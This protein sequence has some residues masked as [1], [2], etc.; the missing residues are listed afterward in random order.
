MSIKIEGKK[1]VVCSSYLFEDD[2]VVFCPVCGAPHHR[3]C[4]NAVG[5]CGV[6]ELHG[7]KDEYRCE[8][9]EEEQPFEATSAKEENVC[10]RCLKTLPP[11]TQFCPY[12][13]MPNANHPNVLNA[14]RNFT[15]NPDEKL[16][17]DITLKEAAKIVGVNTA[18]YIPK[19]KQLSKKNKISWN[20]AAFLLPHSWFA[21][22]KMYNAAFLAGAAMIAG[23]LFTI[24]LLIVMQGLPETEV[25]NYLEVVK[26]V[27]V[28][29]SESGIVPI[30]FTMIS[31]ILNLG[32]RILSALFGDWI[33]R[34]KVIEKVKKLRESEDKENDIVKLGG[35]STIGAC[36]AFLVVYMLPNIL[37]IFI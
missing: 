5:K 33:Y 28:A 10:R 36:I 19:F 18:R 2:D 23:T 20:W 25:E 16:E 8:E 27:S 37:A 1:C 7:T 11:D 13:G 30:I 31:G 17:E 32:V 21:L 29:L 35:V 22:R 12:C 34:C 6:A 14:F 3:D 26:L 4:Y 15:V 9:K 24:P